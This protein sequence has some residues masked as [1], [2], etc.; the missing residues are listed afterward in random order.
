MLAENWIRERMKQIL[1]TSNVSITVTSE[2]MGF[3]KAYLSQIIAGRKNPSLQGICR[4]CEHFEIPPKEFFSNSPNYEY[5]SEY[6]KQNCTKEELRF[7]AELIQDEKKC[8]LV[9]QLVMAFS[10]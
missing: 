8:R 7:I 5:G 4:F 1:E 3:N 10:Q 6:L 2:L 9:K